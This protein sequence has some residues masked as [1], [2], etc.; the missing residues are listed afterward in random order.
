MVLDGFGNKDRMLTEPSM[1]FQKREDKGHQGQ[2]SRKWEDTRGSERG[3]SGRWGEG[4]NTD[5]YYS[6][7]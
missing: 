5:P 3:P 1:T 4:E 7:D 6:T 2:S